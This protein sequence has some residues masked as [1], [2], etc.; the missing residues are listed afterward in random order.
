LYRNVNGKGK[1]HPRTGNED[2]EREERYCSTFSLT[3]ALDGG[4]W[5]TPRPGRFT[6]GKE[7]RYL[8]HRRLCGLQGQSGRVRKISPP[9]TG[10]RSPD[11]PA[12]SES[13]NRLSYPGP[14]YMNVRL[15]K[16]VGCNQEFAP[17]ITS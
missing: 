14:L 8:L 12:R 11:R 9:P 4:E 10:V 15:L 3:S 16:L 17:A 6:P 7:T 1:G 13:L 5:S 2:P